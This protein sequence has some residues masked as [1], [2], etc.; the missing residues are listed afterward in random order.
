MPALNRRDLFRLGAAGAAAAVASTQQRKDRPNILF[1][2]TD[3][4]RGD[5]IGADG[6]RAIKTPNLD[7]LAAEGA[8]F[9]CA[10]SS[11]PSCTPARAALL[12]GLSPWHHGMV[13]YSRVAE[14]YPFEKP[15]VLSDGFQGACHRPTPP[16]INARVSAIV[17]S[18]LVHRPS[19]LLKPNYSFCFRAPRDYAAGW[20]AK[21]STLIRSSSFRA[22]ARS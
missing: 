10:Y 4:Q 15:R 8:R 13:G 22:C 9:R 12:T 3:Q 11:T 6:N 16:L 17:Q 1:L 5:C 14:R 20:G 21:P 19:H 7:R 2:M 18:M